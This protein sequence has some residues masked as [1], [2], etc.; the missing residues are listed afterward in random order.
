MDFWKDKLFAPTVNPPDADDPAN[1]LYMKSLKFSLKAL[2]V[3]R[4]LQQWRISEACGCKAVRTMREKGR[5]LWSVC[6]L[7]KSKSCSSLANASQLELPFVVLGEARSDKIGIDQ[8][9]LMEY[10]F[11]SWFYP[12]VAQSM[13]LAHV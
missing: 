6:I 5:F 3:Y 8:V 10:E 1:E 4:V 7:C 13:L 9:L 2:E 12:T 11:S